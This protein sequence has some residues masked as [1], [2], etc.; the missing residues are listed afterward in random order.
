[1]FVRD[2][3]STPVITVTK[4]TTVPEAI[5]LMKEHNI[6]HLPVVDKDGKLVGLLSDTD[7]NKYM[8]SEATTLDAFELSYLLSKVTVDHVMK[9]MVFTTHPDISVEEAAMEMYDRG[10]NSLPV[11]EGEKVVGII[12]EKDIFRELIDIT[13]VRNGGYRICVV[14]KDKPGS[15]KEVA[16]IIRDAGFG[17]ESVLSSHTCTREGYRKVVL[18][19]RGEGNGNKMKENIMKSYP[20]AIIT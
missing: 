7:I 14:V 2:W 5:K 12:T 13:G 16:D 10:V 19:T 6:R 1:M 9:T 18:R 15:I 17:I 4:K 11:V 8:P 3:M 20:D